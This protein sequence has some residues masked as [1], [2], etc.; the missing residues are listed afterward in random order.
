MS[1]WEIKPVTWWFSAIWE[2]V[3]HISGPSL[4]AVRRFKRILPWPKTQW[5]FDPLSLS[6]IL[7]KY[8]TFR[9]RDVYTENWQ[10]RPPFRGHTKNDPA[11]HLPSHA[12]RVSSDGPGSYVFHLS[13]IFYFYFGKIL[14]KN[15]NLRCS[16]F[17]H[18]CTIQTSSTGPCLLIML[19]IFGRSK[20]NLCSNKRWRYQFYSWW[21]WPGDV[22][23][24]RNREKEETWSLIWWTYFLLH[25]YCGVSLHAGH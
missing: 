14:A 23:R 6:D 19:M 7:E 3:N 17:P 16:S 22:R 18:P 10:T 12:F 11:P 1:L 15:F 13:L 2:P 9:L 8:A 24:Q 5:H 20:R 4:G 25:M 21:S